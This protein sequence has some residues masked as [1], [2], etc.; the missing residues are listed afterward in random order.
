MVD[1]LK[2]R[3]ASQVVSL[4]FRDGTPHVHIE[5]IVPVGCEA[6]GERGRVRRIG[7]QRPRSLEPNAVGG[8]LEGLVRQVL[9]DVLPPIHL[10]KQTQSLSAARI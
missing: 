10:E 6:L 9:G 2:A 4:H 7:G 3:V 1:L 8:A 5:P